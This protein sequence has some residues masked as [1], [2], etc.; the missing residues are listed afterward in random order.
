MRGGITNAVQNPGR[1]SLNSPIN[2]IYPVDINYD[3]LGKRLRLERKNLHYTQEEVAEAVN[4]TPA[5]IGH[6]E[7]GERSL[8]LDTLVKLCNFYGVTIDYV[9]TDILPPNENG[10]TEQ[11]RSLLK[12]KT[13]D[14]QAAILDII[15]TVSR[16]I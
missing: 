9:F 10:I 11:I 15:K 6:I 1:N 12:D 4:V 13:K 2:R 7:R 16:H 5:F 14:Q 8:S 3:S